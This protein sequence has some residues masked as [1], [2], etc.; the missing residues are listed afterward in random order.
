MNN[1]LMLSII[2]VD[3]CCENYTK[4][5]S[6]LYFVGESGMFS[7]EVFGKYISLAVAL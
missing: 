3:I 1:V 5:I 2:N 6:S 7:A 4:A